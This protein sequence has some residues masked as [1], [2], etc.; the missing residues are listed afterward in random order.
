MPAIESTLASATRSQIEFL[1]ID[2]DLAFT[3]LNLAST[4][5]D[6]ETSERNQRNARKAYNSVARFAS[7]PV[8]TGSDTSLIWERLVDLKR[9]LKLTGQK[10]K[11][12]MFNRESHP[13]PKFAAL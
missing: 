8:L 3:L 2:I 10:F 6:P 12:N 4:M 7:H 11:S 9:V 1:L 5:D 13:V